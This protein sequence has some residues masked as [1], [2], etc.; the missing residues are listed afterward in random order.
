MIGNGNL[1]LNYQ[2]LAGFQMTPEQIA[3]NKTR[4]RYVP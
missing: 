4:G 2:L 1:P 3:Y